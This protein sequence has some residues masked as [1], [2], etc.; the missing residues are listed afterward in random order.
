[1]FNNTDRK[2]GQIEAAE[3]QVQDL[4]LHV[5]AIADALDLEALHESFGD[6]DDQVVRERANEAMVRLRRLGV[7][8]AL[9]R[10]RTVLVLHLDPGRDLAAKFALRA[11]HGDSEAIEAHGHLVG[12]WDGGFTDTRHDCGSGS[13]AHQNCH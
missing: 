10:E 3:Q 13:L 4:A 1:M 12:N 6:T 2:D 5:G 9:E 7:V 11:L 8:G